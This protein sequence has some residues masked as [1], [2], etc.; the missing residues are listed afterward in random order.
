[1]L[2]EIAL[3]Y[4][5]QSEDSLRLIG[6]GITVAGAVIAA[7]FNKS[8]AE[9]QRAPYFAY[10]GLLLLIVA[11]GQLVWLGSIPA[12]IG[13]YLWVFMSIDVAV[14]LVAG[15]GY[16]VIA[17]ARSRDAY[18]HARMAFLALIP[19]ANF[20]LLLTPSK[21]SMSANRAPTIA[22]LTGGLG[23]LTGFILFG[24]GIALS[25]FVK[26]EGER[27]AAEAQSDPAM[28]QAGIDMMLRVQG[29]EQTL[30]MMAAEVPP[31]RVDEV[32]ALLRVS[33]EGTT[34]RYQ[35]EVT[36]GA[37][38]LPMSLRV[39]LVQ[40]NCTNEAMRLLIQGGATIQHV[41]VSPDGR[42]IGTVDVTRSLCGY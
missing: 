2:E 13:H 26:V 15:Y 6:Y 11:A 29:L 39:G 28:Q 8:Q 19:F 20:W 17:K 24:V 41:Y 3:Q 10:S 4:V 21:N 16:G 33:S 35:Y 31:Q 18:G 38:V 7:V 36:S 14:G 5:N 37:A 23:V 25:A 34:L 42:E 30:A 22:L 32:T 27:M 1:M 12:M 40:H 9:L